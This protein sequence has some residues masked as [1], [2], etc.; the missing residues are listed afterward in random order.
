MPL[1]FQKLLFKYWETGPQLEYL[2]GSAHAQWT[3]LGLLP[4]SRPLCGSAAPHRWFCSNHYL[5][6]R[7]WLWLWRHLELKQTCLTDYK[8]P[9][10]CYFAYLHNILLYLTYWNLKMSQ[11]VIWMFQHMSSYGFS[12]WRCWVIIDDLRTGLVLKLSSMP[13]SLVDNF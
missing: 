12:R 10:Q 11:I 4:S 1:N 9:T 3:R 5:F 13:K 2:L 8:E 7:P 6:T